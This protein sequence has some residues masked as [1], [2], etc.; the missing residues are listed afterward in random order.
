MTLLEDHLAELDRLERAGDHRAA[1]AMRSAVDTWLSARLSPGA[2]KLVELAPHMCRWPMGN[3][4]DPM[5]RWCCAQRVDGSSYCAAH[6][7]EA[8]LPGFRP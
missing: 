1:D 5:F 8:R 7:A 2:R 4:D 3:L 6:K